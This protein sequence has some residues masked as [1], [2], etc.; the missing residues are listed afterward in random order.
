MKKFY[1]GILLLPFLLFAVVGFGQTIQWINTGATTA[2]YTAGNW[3]PSTSSG[4]WTTANLAQFNNTGTATRAGINMNTASLSIGAIE[5]SSLRTRPLTIGSSSLSGN[6]TLNSITVNG[7]NN[8]V[9]RN[10]ATSGDLILQDNETGTGKLM[11][12]VLGNAT[13]NVIVVDG[14]G[15]VEISSIVSGTNRPLTIQGAGSGYASLSGAANTFTGTITILAREL[16]LSAAGSAGNVNNTIVVN[17]GILGT[18]SGNSFTL[19]STHAIQVS[20]SA[21]NAIAVNGAGTLTYGGVISNFSGTGFLTKQG[22]GTLILGGVSTY[23]GATT[24][25]NGSI[26]LSTGAN[27]LP[28]ATILSLGQTASTNL[29]TFNLDGNSQQIAGLA[30]IAGTNVS[31]SKNTVTSATAATLTINGATD[32]TFSGGTNANSGTIT[33]AITLVKAGTGTQTFGEANT[34]TGTT[35]ITG[36]FIAGGNENIFGANPGAFTP[37]QITLN[38]GGFMSTTA[39]SFSSNRGI[40]LGASGGSFD[41]DGG[42]ITL[43]TVVTG[44]GKLTKLS[45]GVL[46]MAGA[47]TYTGGTEI[48]D[49]VV[50]LAA[51]ERLADTGPI[52]LNG[53]TLRSGATVGFT[54]TMGTLQLTDNSIITLGTGNHSLFFAASNGIGWTAGRSLTIEGWTGT[55]GASGTAGKIFVGTTATGLTATQLA[56]ITFD[57]YPAG[58]SILSTGEI[59]PQ[60]ITTPFI[61]LDHTNINQTPADDVLPGTND[62]ILSNFRVNVVNVNDVLDEI[63]FTIGGTFVAGDVANFKLYTSLTPVFP[64]GAA[65]STVPAGAIASG[66]T[67]TFASLGRSCTVGNRYFWITADI[68]AAAVINNTVIAP[69]LADADFTFVDGIINTNNITVGGT[70][71]IVVVITPEFTAG[72]LTAFPNTCVSA[73][74]GPNSFTLTGT[75]LNTTDISIGPLA[76]FEFSD[77]NVNFYSNLNI[78]QPGGGFSGTIYVR[79]LPA[80]AI[81][82]SGNIPISGAGAATVNVAASGTG[83]NT[84]AGL[85]T[86]SAILITTNSAVLP[87]T[88]NTTGCGIVTDYGIEYASGGIFT[89]GTGTQVPA[90]NLASGDFSVPFTGLTPGTNYY[91]YAYAVSGGV[92]TYGAIQSFSTPGVPVKLVIVSVTPNPATVQTAFSVTVQALDALDNPTDVTVDTDITLSKSAGAANFVFPNDPAAAG[93]IPAGS[94]TVIIDDV[95]YLAVEN[96]VGL[97]ASATAGMALTASPSFVFNVIAYTGPTSFTWQGDGTGFGSAWLTSSNWIGGTVPGVSGAAVINN[98]LANFAGVDGVNVSFGLGLNMN[99]ASGGYNMGA[100]YISPAYTFAGNGTGRLTLGNSV[101]TADGTWRMYGAPLTNVGGIAGNNFTSLLVANYM[102]HP[103][104]KTFSFINKAGTFANRNFTLTLPVAGAM[105][106]GVGRTIE[107]NVLMT[108]TNT[109]TFT[110]GGAFKL[111]PVNASD[112]VVNNTFSGAMVVASGT[113]TVGN[114]GAI[115]V[116]TPNNITLGSATGPTAGILRLDGNSVTIGGIATAGTLGNANIIDN[117]NATATITIQNAA[118]NTFAGSLKD[119]SSGN[120]SLVKNAAGI[121]N[122]TGQSTYTGSTTINAG[123]LQLSRVGGGTLASATSVTISGGTLRVSSNQTVTNLTLTS[124]NLQVDAGV[125]L[126]ITGN[127]TATGG[128]LINSGTIEFNGTDPQSFPGAS[129]TVTSMNN[130]HI[131]S[132]AAV[133]MNKDL[134]IA[135]VLTLTSGIFNIQANTLTINNPIAGTPGNLA[136]ISTSSMVIAGTVANVNIPSS[137]SVLT[138]LTVSNTVGTVLQGNLTV[139]GQVLISSAGTVDAGT[140]TFNGTASVTISANSTLILA[141]NG[142]T[143]PEF[144]GIY[145]ITNGTVNF[146][147]S[148]AQTIRGINYFNLTTS[149]TGSRLVPAS[150]TVGIAAVFTKGVGNIFSFANGSTVNYNSSVAQNIVA[151]TAGAGIGNT[152]HH[153]SLSNGG[154]KTLTGATDVEGELTLN[155][156]VTLALGSNFITLKSTA[157][158]TARLATVPATA[159]IN[160]GTGRFVVERYFPGKRA[161]RLITA[162]VTVDAA[163]TL[164]NSWQAGGNNGVGDNGTYITGPGENA[165][166]GFDVSPMHNHSLKTFNQLTSQFDGVPGTKGTNRISGTAGV[167]GTPDNIGYFM[168]VRGDRTSGNPDPFNSSIIGNSTTLRDTGLIQYRSYT[169]NCNPSTGTHRYTLIGNPYASPVDFAGLALN[170]V[171]NKFW[172]WDPT[173]NGVNGVGGYVIVDMSGPTITTVPVGGV[174]TQNQIIQSKQAFLVETTGSS[175]TVTFNETAKSS[176]NNLSLF[177]PAATTSSSL[178]VNLY[179]VKAG[180]AVLADGVLAQFSNDYSDWKDHL[181]GLKFGNVNETFSIEHNNSFYML[182]RRKLLT[183]QDTVFFSLRRSRPSKYRFHVMNKDL[184]ANRNLVAYMEDSYLKTST[185]LRMEGDSWIDFEVTADA[186]SAAANRFFIVFK[187]AARFSKISANIVVNDVAVNW[188]TESQAVIGHYEIERSTD[189]VHFEKVGEVAA[190]QHAGNEYRFTDL[191]PAPGI[192]YYRVKGVS[193]SYGVYE[194]TEAVKVKVAKASQQLYVYPNP[195]TDGVI[196]LQMNALPAGVY[197]VRLLTANGQAVLKKQL[198]HDNGAATETITYPGYL[199]GG[200]YQLEVVGPD[201]KQHVVTVVIVQK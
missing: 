36:G 117:G 34:Y 99:T 164:F 160:H 23:T 33:G 47:H 4:A 101:T 132:A 150:G 133:S 75:S 12:V 69:A 80:A 197:N 41:T 68:D 19:A 26:Q 137:V 171:A 8:V 90:S 167:A 169:F 174:T 48:I 82:Y 66:G 195:V 157:T 118:G 105:V 77:D 113:L 135:G 65:Y 60:A 81:A 5:L 188:A 115:N 163:K 130:L 116:T 179:T 159:G 109:L 70:K 18:T 44:T 142:V 110:G 193:S 120:L 106:A 154:V 7:V 15:R 165:T 46:N 172:A 122:F 123:T 95:S 45:A 112:V 138:N 67:V 124:G 94:S 166:N 31:G 126:T 100:I 43:T 147:G 59:V 143:Q 52:I 88:I 2:W 128:T 93:T 89:A 180:G 161:W 20:A 53:G 51:S 191:S 72:P 71:T 30:S 62:V 6:L 103:T 25:N 21:A 58:V 91:Y 145:N 183:P 14:P 173:L 97:I 63:T 54:E 73:F 102:S 176:V 10:A 184:I 49:G 186:G 17:G 22:A 139:S 111:A 182:E 64:G 50:Q 156:F 40:T 11:N 178:A 151:F 199:T 96:N 146:A 153:L 189:G 201:R 78:S 119:G 86:G 85:T 32:N 27:R 29:G 177:R 3:S 194:H 121:L 108:G 158:K 92:T 35:T 56:Q 131:N 1:A 198:V 140:N 190:E 125:T 37:A 181:D 84:G 61:T 38:G 170:N 39:V 155:G 141:K 16:Q 134:N 185:P 24:I 192:Y 187:K 200:T 129:T 79:F 175:P 28:V 55:A 42:D 168:F 136:S 9:L 114:A 104:D 149:S 196:G 98:H 162:P 74:A 87:G 76:G 13:N 107:V 152:Y 83:I 57:G 144:T 148:G 127:Y